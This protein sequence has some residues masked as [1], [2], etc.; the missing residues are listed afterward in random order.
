MTVFLMMI[1]QSAIFFLL[2]LTHF[3]ICNAICASEHL[4]YVQQC[5]RMYVYGYVEKMHIF[6]QNCIIQSS[7]KTRLDFHFYAVS[8]QLK[9]VSHFCIIIE[10]LFSS[11]VGHNLQNRIS[12]KTGLKF[13]KDAGPLLHHPRGWGFFFFVFFCRQSSLHFFDERLQRLSKRSMNGRE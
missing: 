1:T 10:P 4:V 7:E 9:P 8:H 12:R 3:C 5:I 13:Q 11:T 2:V 6:A